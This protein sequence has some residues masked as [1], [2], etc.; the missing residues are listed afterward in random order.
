LVTPTYS[1]D[2]RSRLEENQYWGPYN[3][4]TFQLMDWMLGKGLMVPQRPEANILVVIRNGAEF[5]FLEI[6]LTRAVALQ[7]VETQIRQVAES[8]KVSF[9]IVQNTKTH[10]AY[11]TLDLFPAFFGA[12]SLVAFEPKQEKKARGNLTGFP[13]LEETT[14]YKI[15]TE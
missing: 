15:N 3:R 4:L 13:P 11:G 1:S 14:I 7:R 8:E 2:L 9:R 5:T 10:P 6:H 12:G